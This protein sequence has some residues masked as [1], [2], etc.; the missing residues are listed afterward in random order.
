MAAERAEG[1]KAG[2]QRG[3]Y[4]ATCY[5]IVAATNI[6]SLP[7]MTCCKAWIAYRQCAVQG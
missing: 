1:E 6:S 5:D 2:F 7:T 4:T 3:D